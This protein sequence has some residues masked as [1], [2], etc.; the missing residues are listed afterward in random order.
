MAGKNTVKLVLY[1]LLLTL[2]F[3]GLVEI[4]T[5]ASGLFLQLELLGLLFLLLLSFV[6]FVNFGKHFGEK[7][8]FFVFL[9]YIANL[10]LMWY[11][12]GSLYFILLLLSLIGFVLSIPRKPAPKKLEFKEPVKE[13]VKEEVKEAP[14]KAVKKTT[15][16]VKHS[17]GKYVASKRSNIYHEPKCEWAKKINKQRRLWFADRK[18]AQKKGFRK[19]SCVN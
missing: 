19:H 1:G 3:F 12:F 10:G 18:E 11:A 14:K 17:P 13:E 2:L 7:L 8:L 15:P 6:G 16:K 5:N 9:L 4:I